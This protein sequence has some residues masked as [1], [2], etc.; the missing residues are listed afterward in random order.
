M[1]DDNK[2]EKKFVN[3]NNNNNANNNATNNASKNQ[4]KNE[5]ESEKKA[6]K[7]SAIKIQSVIRRFLVSTRFKRTYN[8]DSDN[9][10]NVTTEE[11]RES[12]CSEET[13]RTVSLYYGNKKVNRENSSRK[14]ASKNK[15]EKEGKDAGMQVKKHETVS[16]KETRKGE[17]KENEKENERLEIAQGLSTLMK[18]DEHCNDKGAVKSMEPVHKLDGKTIKL[19][20][21]HAAAG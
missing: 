16:K 19:L 18:A 13:Q 20:L 5:N 10:S 8:Y 11:K 3:E 6:A 7:K 15:N 9:N 17:V 12:N 1:K 14:C 2:S 4:I 21:F